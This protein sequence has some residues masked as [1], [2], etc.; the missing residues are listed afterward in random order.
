MKRQELIQMLER[1]Q[2]DYPE[3]RCFIPR[4]LSLLH[5]FKMCYTRGMITGHMTASAFITNL[6]GSSILLTH[7]KKLNRWL[8]PG[9]HADG[10]E[11]MKEV[12][13]KEGLEETG[14]S[15]LTLFH[16]DIFDID[17][18]QIPAYKG[19]PAHFHYDIRF[20]F[21]ADP[22]EPL[23]ISEESHNLAWIGIDQL[24]D[25]TGNNR[26][27]LRMSEKLNLFFPLSII[28]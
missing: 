3:E 18:H 21:T 15:S 8:Q 24:A 19:I 11:D 17:I 14:L 13:F 20:L 9:G 16:N 12:A 25:V 6:P 2:T 4:F 27:I 1:Y 5:N 22:E 23:H 26:S 28:E 10:V 7:H